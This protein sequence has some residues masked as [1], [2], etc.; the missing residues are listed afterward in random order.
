[1][2]HIAKPAKDGW[3]SELLVFLYYMFMVRLKRSHVTKREE[4]EILVSLVFIFIL[5]CYMTF[6]YISIYKQLK[7]P[8]ELWFSK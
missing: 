6:S 1:M 8:I 3:F 2:P 4:I 7:F 5:Y